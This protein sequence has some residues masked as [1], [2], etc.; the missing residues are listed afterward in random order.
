M[1]RPVPRHKRSRPAQVE[2]KPA[3]RAGVLCAGIAVEDFIFRVDRFPTP[4]TKTVVE[5]FVVTGGGCAANAAIAIAR[6]GGLARFAG[7]LGDEAMSDRI[8]AG[9]AGEGVD[10][11]GVERVAGGVASFSGIF[12]DP[13]G[14]RLLA[15]RR[16][17][18]LRKARAADPDALLRGIAVV[19]ADNHFPEFVLPICRGARR[20][21]LAVVLDVDRAAKPDDPLLALA[22]HPIFSAEA[23]RGTSGVDELAAALARAG[24]FCRGGFVAV[25]D[26]A[27]GVLW[28]EGA[29]SGHVSAFAIEAVDTLAA[30]DVFHGAFALAL[31]ER[32]EER[33][34]L[35]F[36][37]AAA[38]LK[39]TRFGGIAGAPTRA[40]VEALMRKTPLA[41]H[42]RDG[43]G[44]RKM[45]NA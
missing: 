24:R 32:C 7:P 19:L 31:A 26:G 10:V 34:A 23:L 43:Q 3:E 42:R 39:C 5:D 6:L 40:A 25:T 45:R 1:K 11:S 12:V 37:A 9:M 30:G 2:R 8:L 13:A 41:T 4:G 29:A 44:R 36:A 21:G 18:G 15:T 27:N 22:T 16:E 20:R 35:R 28:Q 17:Q 38:G 33:R 14:E